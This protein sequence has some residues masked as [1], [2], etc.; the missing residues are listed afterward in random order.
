MGTNTGFSNRTTIFWKPTLFTSL[1]FE[2]VWLP[3]IEYIYLWNECDEWCSLLKDFE[4]NQKRN[5][6]LNTIGR[7]SAQA[8]FLPFPFSSTPIPKGLSSPLMRFQAK[9]KLILEQH[10]FELHRSTFMHFWY[11]HRTV[12]YNPW[13]W[14]P[15]Y[16][17]LTVKL[18]VN[19][20]LCRGLV[21]QTLAVFKD[22]EIRKYI[23]TG[24]S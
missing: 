14:K 24:K 23:Q 20:Q 19:F 2:F 7:G 18:P 11:I 17:G 9:Y 21:P 8:C 16:G 15:R 1:V 13:V 5:I 12:V 6:T 10:R 3:E 22:K 4:W